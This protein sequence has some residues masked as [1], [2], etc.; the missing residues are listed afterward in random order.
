MFPEGAE[1]RELPLEEGA[2]LR[3]Y[4]FT[5][6]ISILVGYDLTPAMYDLSDC[7]EP[8]LLEVFSELLK[9]STSLSLEM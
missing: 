8:I 3:P 4:V 1:E 7:C 5:V 9:N 6:L 2:A